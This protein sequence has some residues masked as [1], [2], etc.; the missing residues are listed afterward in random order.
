MD[1]YFSRGTKPWATTFWVSLVASPFIL[2]LYAIFSPSVVYANNVSQVVQTLRTEPNSTSNNQDA[3]LGGDPQASFSSSTQGH[4]AEAATAVA[5]AVSNVLTTIQEKVS[6]AATALAEAIQ[7]KTQEIVDHVISVGAAVNKETAVT[8]VENNPTTNAA[9]QAASSLIQEAQAAVQEADSATAVAIA[10][11]QAVASQTSVVAI[12]TTAVSTAQEDLTTATTNLT[13]AQENLATAQTTLANSSATE[14]TAPGLVVKVYDIQGQNQAPVIPNGATPIHTEVTTNGVNGNWGSGNV[15]GSTKSEDVIVTYEGQVTAPEGVN[16]IR[17]LVLSDDGARI[18]IDNV[19]VVDQWVDQGPT[20][21]NPSP[22]IDFTNDRTKTISLWYYENGGGAMVHLAWQHSGI[23]TGVGAEYLS[24]NTITQDPT[25]V[26]AVTAAQEVV[27]DKTEVKQEA[28]TAFASAQITLA[29]ETE[30]LSDLQS[31]QDEAI[32][33]ANELADIATVKVQ[34]AVTAMNNAVSVVQ[35]EFQPAPTPTPTP[36]PK[37][38]PQPA[39]QPEPQP[40]SEPTPEPAPE[41]QSEPTPEPEPKSQEEPELETSRQPSPTPEPE[42]EPEPKPE[43]EPEPTEEE[44]VDNAVDDALLDGEIDASDAEKILDILGS[45]GEITA[46]EVNNLADILAE[47]GELTSAEKELIAD[48]LIESADGE[49]LTAE[50][51]ADAGLSYEDLPAETPVEVR[52]DEDGNEVVITAEVAAALEVLANPAEL[53]STLFDDPAQALLALGSI[54]A[55]MSSEERKEATEAIVATVVAASAAMNAVG[56]AA[57]AAGSS[58]SGGSGGGGSSGGGAS[59]G[60]SKG[61]RR[62]NP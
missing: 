34:E 6:D 21:S 28:E 2:F 56:A 38:E 4:N 55:D 36:T 19:L 13:E 57:G 24:H 20:W 31:T 58:S 11:A 5:T 29:T 49:A 14:T 40:E 10:A 3:F 27:V 26:A 15:A 12:A 62:R 61:I 23:H 32:E 17:F 16:S 25:L 22:W 8:A 18:Y 39:P 60:D 30:T 54:G 51:I 48:A 47:D 45:D 43:P 7:T 35:S 46:E 50:A 42:P 44:V 37:P 9:V 41:P 33:T 1:A 59:S 52:Q 53:L